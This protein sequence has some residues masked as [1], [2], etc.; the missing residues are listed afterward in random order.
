MVA[1]Q[2]QNGIGNGRTMREKAR[3]AS[4]QHMQ[5]QYVRTMGAKR[6]GYYVRMTG[7]KWYW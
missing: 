4:A 2:E 6:C 7:A 1:Q 3:M 5:K